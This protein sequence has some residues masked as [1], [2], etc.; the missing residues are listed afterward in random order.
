MFQKQFAILQ[1]QFVLL[2]KQFA[3]L[4]KQFAAFQKQFVMIIAMP[5]S[6]YKTHIIIN[7]K[8]VKTIIA[9]NQQLVKNYFIIFDKK[10]E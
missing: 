5:V 10:K 1:K 7:Q 2:Q 8:K 3:T 9:G 4:Q 6:Y